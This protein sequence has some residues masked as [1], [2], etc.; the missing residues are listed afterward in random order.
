MM[1]ELAIKPEIVAN[2]DTLLVQHFVKLMFLSSER[3][4][5]LSYFCI[6]CDYDK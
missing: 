1:A 4:V 6:S 5:D 3:V 2:F